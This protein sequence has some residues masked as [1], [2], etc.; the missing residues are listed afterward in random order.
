MPLEALSGVNQQSMLDLY[1]KVCLL[2]MNPI[3]FLLIKTKRHLTKSWMPLPSRRALPVFRL[4]V[5]GTE[6]HRTSITL[7]SSGQTHESSP[8]LSTRSNHIHA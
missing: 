2:D 3:T 1:F 5:H 7:S 8:S 6:I 4:H